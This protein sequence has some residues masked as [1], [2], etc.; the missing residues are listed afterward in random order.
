MT[1]LEVLQ[2]AGWLAA[3]WLVTV[4]V[5]VARGRLAPGTT[6][7]RTAGGAA[8]VVVVA[9]CAAASLWPVA[10]LGLLWLRSEVFG[11]RHPATVPLFTPQHG[12][13]VHLGRHAVDVI[14]KIEIALVVVVAAVMFVTWAMENG[15][16]FHNRTDRT[17]C[18]LVDGC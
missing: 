11:H 2:A 4:Q 5:L 16:A 18:E 6:A 1:V 8:A 17:L 10:V 7:V 15:V 14:F 13:R 3:V 12:P 9:A